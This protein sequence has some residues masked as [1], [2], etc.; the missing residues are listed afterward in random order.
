MKERLSAKELGD[1]Y[2]PSAR[3]IVSGEYTYGQKTAG[4]LGGQSKI[5]VEAFLYKS[6]E[7]IESIRVMCGG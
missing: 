1:T 2:D 3:T 7:N 5:L 6:G 4:W